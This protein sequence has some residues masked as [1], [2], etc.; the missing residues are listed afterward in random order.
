MSFWTASNHPALTA[1]NARAKAA[2][3]FA[4]SGLEQSSLLQVGVWGGCTPVNPPS[5]CF[6]ACSYCLKHVLL[7]GLSRPILSAR[8]SQHG[9]ACSH[10]KTRGSSCQRTMEKGPRSA[11][12]AA[13]RTSAS[14]S[15]HYM[16]RRPL[17]GQ[18][19]VGKAPFAGG[20]PAHPAGRRPPRAG[21]ASQGRRC[22]RSLAASANSACGAEVS[23]TPHPAEA[24][25]VL[26]RSLGAPAP[27]PPLGKGPAGAGAPPKRTRG[28]T[29][30]RPCRSPG[31]PIGAQG[32]G[33]RG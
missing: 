30:R 19:T 11:L 14:G 1:R 32:C 8:P 31:R 29:H 12:T 15:C 16:A 13:K 26:R 4:G 24:P 3:R 5:S 2:T 23:L 25:Q 20:F 22:P 18:N 17:P 33:S 7:P 21:G 28:T 27:R 6:Q 9:S 10:C